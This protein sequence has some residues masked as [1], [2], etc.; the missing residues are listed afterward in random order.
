VILIDDVRPPTYIAS[1]RSHPAFAKMRAKLG[2]H[3]NQWMGDVYRLMYFIDTFCQ[4][5]TY[6]TIS[7]NHG[8]AVV[9]RKRRPSV[10]D[11]TLTEI[12]QLTFEEFC[13]TD[14]VLRSAPLGKIEP[15]MRADLGLERS[16]G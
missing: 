1:L 14:D 2:A 10:T 8:Q 13:L 6:R 9:W 7:N 3:E 12:G 5:L 15:E 11:R 16:A 4:Q